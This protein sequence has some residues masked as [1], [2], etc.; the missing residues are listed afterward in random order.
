MGQLSDMG[1]FTNRAF[2]NSDVNYNYGPVQIRMSKGRGYHATIGYICLFV[3][4]ATRAIHLEAVSDLKQRGF[5]AAFRIM[6]AYGTLMY[7][8]RN[9]IY[10][11]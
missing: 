7:S 2:V 3:C 11:E 10:K 1:V 6:V 4:I 8:R 9:D 5:V